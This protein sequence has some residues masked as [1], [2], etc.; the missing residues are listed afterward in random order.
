[1]LSRKEKLA[2]MDVMRIDG[3][4][5]GVDYKT[6]AWMSMNLDSLYYK[7]TKSFKEVRLIEKTPKY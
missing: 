4:F 6:I 1:M 3:V 2:G 7:N 5:K